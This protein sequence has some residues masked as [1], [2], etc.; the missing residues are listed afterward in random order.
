MCKYSPWGKKVTDSKRFP[1][2]RSGDKY[3]DNEVDFDSWI[4]HFT[5]NSTHYYN[6]YHPANFQ[7]RALTSDNS[8]VGSGRGGFN[9]NITLAMNTYKDLDFVALVEFVHESQ[10]ILYYRLGDKAPPAAISYLS[11]SCHCEKQYEECLKN[12]IHIRHHDMAKRSNLR[13]LPPPTLSKVANLT[14]ADSIIYVNALKNFMTEMAWLES[15]D[16]LGRRVV[17]DDVLKKWEPELAYLDGGHL[18]VT[19]LYH[20]AVEKH[21]GI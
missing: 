3:E 18:N 12:E 15:D 8:Y 13:D 20:D 5:V 7:S 1:F 4:N 11:K 16:A 9:P 19:Q 17:C 6:C 2:P 10:C 14:S 21:L